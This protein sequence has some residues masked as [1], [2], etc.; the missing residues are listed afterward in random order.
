L[1]VGHLANSRGI[2]FVFVKIWSDV[3]LD[4][5]H[6]SLNFWLGFT[7][8]HPNVPIRIDR[9]GQILRRTNLI[10]LDLRNGLICRATFSSCTAFYAQVMHML[11]I[12]HQ[13]RYRTYTLSGSSCTNS[14]YRCPVCSV[15]VQTWFSLSQGIVLWFIY[16]Y[17][18]FFPLHSHSRFSYSSTNNKFFD[19]LAV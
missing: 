12:F 4:L 7:P 8:V 14:L 19:F 9:F 3:S 18:P 17:N 16:L 15:Q 10:R 11:K 13:P 2:Q 6:S 5:T 1:Q